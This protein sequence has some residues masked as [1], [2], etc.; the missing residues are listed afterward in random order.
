MMA[1]TAITFMSKSMTRGC[2]SVADA[3]GFDD[4]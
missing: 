1:V 3:H 2:H 4:W